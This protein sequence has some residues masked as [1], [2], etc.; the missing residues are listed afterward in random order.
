MGAMRLLQNPLLL[1]WVMLAVLT[2]M[3][4]PRPSTWRA[5]TIIICWIFVFVELILLRCAVPWR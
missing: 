5:W 2:T 3:I 4:G 1:W